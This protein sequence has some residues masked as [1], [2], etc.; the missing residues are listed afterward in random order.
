MKMNQDLKVKYGTGLVA[1]SISFFKHILLFAVLT[2][3]YGF[4]I[5]IISALALAAVFKA[6]LYIA[7]FLR[8]LI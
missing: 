6:I 4:Y 7:G 8:T 5:N 1:I 2:Y 3:T